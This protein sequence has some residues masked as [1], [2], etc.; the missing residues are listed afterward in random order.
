MDAWVRQALDQYQGLRA[1]HGYGQPAYGQ[2]AHGYG[3]P[4]ATAR[5]RLPAAAPAARLW[6]RRLRPARRRALR[7][8]P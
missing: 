1:N 2:P 5:R 4:A 8:S 3:A 6:S 7:G